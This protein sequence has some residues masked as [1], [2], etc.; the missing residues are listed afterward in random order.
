[1]NLIVIDATL[2]R[3]KNDSDWSGV[4]NIMLLTRLGRIRA[5]FLNEMRNK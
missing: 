3:D 1:L 5:G 4:Q 2:E